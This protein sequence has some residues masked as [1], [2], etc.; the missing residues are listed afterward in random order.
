M[1]GT[2]KKRRY[3]PIEAVF[4]NLPKESVPALLPFHALMGCDT[5]SYIAN[6][7]KRSSWEVFKDHNKLLE[8]L[9]IGEL[10]DV[11][12]KASEAFVCRIYNVHKTDSVDDAR[13]I[14]FCKTTKPEA[15]PPT[16]DALRFHLMRVYYQTM[17]WRNAHCATPE[18][19]SPVQM[20]WM[21]NTDSGLQP[22][23]MS[24]SPIPES[25]LEMISCAC[26]KQCQ[27]RRCKCR[28]SAL[29]CTSMC[30]CQQ[31][32]DEQKHC[33]NTM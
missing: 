16:S 21:K 6:H 23:L 20:G 7:T 10:T 5:T 18:L 2:S 13:H 8:N 17:I 1:S 11:T 3:I 15:L 12:I 25:C 29:R 22:I 24:L 14:L 33:M 19:P 4:T 32:N 28:K 26:R 30:T 27:T 31:Q 9:G